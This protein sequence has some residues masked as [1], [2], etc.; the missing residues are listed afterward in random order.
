MKLLL[1][2]VIA[3]L[4]ALGELDRAK[5]WIHRALLLDPDNLLM[6]YNFACT[7]ARSRSDP[8]T[9]L[10]ML[11]PVLERNAGR[12]VTN[13]AT[14]P[15]LAPLRGDPRFQAMLAAANARLA[16]AEPTDGAAANESA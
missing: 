7:L 4:A 6:R 11:A 13:A 5:D 14:D 9:A 15:D 10:R 16:A 1:L 12:I 2:C 3:A 8:D